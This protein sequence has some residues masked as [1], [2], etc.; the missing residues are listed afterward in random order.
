MGDVASSMDYI[1]SDCIPE[2]SSLK[3]TV[4]FNDVIARQ[5]YRYNSSIEGQKKKNQRKK[6]K[7]RSQ[8]RRKSESEAEE[9]TNISFKTSKPRLKSVLK[10]RRDSGLADTSD[11]EAEC[12]NLRSDSEISCD[13]GCSNKKNREDAINKNSKECSQNNMDK[14]GNSSN[15]FEQHLSKSKKQTTTEIKKPLNPVTCD[16][17]KHNTDL[18]NPDKLNKGQYQEVDFKN[19]LIFDLDM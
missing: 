18:Y 17:I 16:N 13:N 10:Q 8:E 12:K 1:S 15:K 4:R 14:N 19:D 3:K 6:S 7:K 5:F 11:A 2:E 9:E